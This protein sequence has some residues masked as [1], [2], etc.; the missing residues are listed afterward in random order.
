MRNSFKVFGCSGAL[1]A[2]TALAQMTACTTDPA[3]DDTST[4]GTGG[5]ADDNGGAGGASTG[6]SGGAG[7]ASTSTGTAPAGATICT[8]EVVL[9]SATPKIADFDTYVEGTDISTWSFGLGGEATTGVYAGP[10]VYGDETTGLPKTSGMVAGNE[11]TYALG[12][13]D[14]SADVYGGGMGLWLSKCLDASAFSGLSFWVSGSTAM[15]KVTLSM[16]E[17]TSTTPAKVGDKPGTCASAVKEA[18]VHPSYAFAVAESDGWKQVKI[19]WGA[20][21]G[22]SAAGTAV[23]ATGKHIVQLQIAAE[24]N[25]IP[26]PTDPTGVKYVAVPAP[27]KLVVDSLAFY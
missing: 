8:G 21:T 22:G 12:I 5:A 14:D 18:C 26:D 4:G 11:T 2:L 25:W 1:V 20:F 19:P 24:L 17:T 7:G 15:A 3:S 13:E 10:F 6:T 23:A 9:G 16:E 27:Y